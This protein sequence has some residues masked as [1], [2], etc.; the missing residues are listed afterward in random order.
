MPNEDSE[1]DTEYNEIESNKQVFMEIDEHLTEEERLE[2]V[3]RCKIRASKIY[4][5]TDMH[6]I[7]R[8]QVGAMVYGDTIDE[9]K[10]QELLEPIQRARQE[11][12]KSMGMNG[13][14]AGVEFKA[15]DKEEN[16]KELKETMERS[17][18]EAVVRLGLNKTEEEA[19]WNMWK[20]IEAEE[21]EVF[22]IAFGGDPPAKLEPLKIRL[23]EG[24]C[25]ENY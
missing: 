2:Y 8:E 4:Q 24:A 25:K 23:K 15:S 16:E 9:K 10:I 13:G 7:P 3:R 22:R 5:V 6:G 1:M 12:V 17:K 11:A 20:S 19:F 21:K 18:K 14:I